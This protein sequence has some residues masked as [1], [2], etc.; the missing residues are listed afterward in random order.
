MLKP[1]NLKSGP[2]QFE[3]FSSGINRKKY[4]Q[5]DYRASN[6]ELFSAVTPTV[7]AARSKRNTWLENKGLE[8]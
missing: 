4:V 3:T 6:G 1:A 7:E 2:E 5:Y 8:D